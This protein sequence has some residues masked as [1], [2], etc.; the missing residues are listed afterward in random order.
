MPGEMDEAEAPLEGP[1]PRGQACDGDACRAG[2][3]ERAIEA[4]LERDDPAPER[5]RARVDPR[6][7]LPHRVGLRGGELEPLAELEDVRGAGVV[8]E[9]GG[10]RVAR[11]LAGEELGDALGRNGL[12]LPPLEPSVGLVPGRVSFLGGVVPGAAERPGD[13]SERRGGSR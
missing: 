6:L 1:D 5:P 2:R 10:E 7:E 11:A 12:D 3:A 4:P 8:V 13:E 9:L